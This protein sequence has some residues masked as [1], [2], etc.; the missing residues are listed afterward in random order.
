LVRLSKEM[1]D[2]A[3]LMLGEAAL[4]TALVLG[5]HWLFPRRSR[6]GQDDVS[7]ERPESNPDE[8]LPSEAAGAEQKWPP[9]AREIAAAWLVVAEGAGEGTH[10]PVGEGLTVIGRGSSCNI[11]LE[12]SSVSRKH[13]R[14]LKQGDQYYIYDLDSTNGTLVDGNLA[15]RQEGFLL[16]NGSVV[17][18]GAA[19]LFFK[20]LS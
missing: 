5:G 8:L 9:L 12:D 1:R 2:I 20:T 15:D 19:T 18:L 11:I 7:D 14:I 3:M 13:A 6:S 17:S 10:H 4:V 16:R